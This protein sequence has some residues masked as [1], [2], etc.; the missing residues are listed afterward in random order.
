MAFLIS[1][2][3]EL[4]I[5]K[6]KM[7]GDTIITMSF[8][9]RV[10]GLNAENFY[11]MLWDQECVEKAEPKPKT[12]KTVQ[13]ITDNIDIMY[14]EVALPFPMSDRDFVQKRLHLNSKVDK[15]IVKELG[16]YD[17]NHNFYIIMIKSAE[18][19]DYPIQKKP[20][21]ADVK[22]NYWLIEED[23]K[24]EGVMIFKTKV[25]QDIGGSV[26]LFFMNDVAP[27]MA[28]KNLETMIDNYY[29][30]FGKA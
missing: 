3:S 15:K 28:H 4:K 11:R 17:W 8:E 6:K 20:I 25:C 18:H 24:E 19:P 10:K 7:E 14:I 1:L 13:K 9:G 29:R 21:R 5:F 30:I 2:D 22:M 26:P 16:L 27:K 23:P 12:F